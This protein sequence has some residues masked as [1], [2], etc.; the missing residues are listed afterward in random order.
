MKGR[1]INLINPP[2]TK[3]TLGGICAAQ[4]GGCVKHPICQTCKLVAKSKS[5]QG[6]KFCWLR[7][8]WSWGSQIFLAF[9]QKK[10]AKRV[11]KSHSVP[12]QSHSRSGG[13]FS[14]HLAGAFPRCKGP[15]R[16]SNSILERSCKICIFEVCR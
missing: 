3:T 4:T 5:E 11:P 15:S 14:K 1:V 2:K 9:P 8:I 6:I 12:C 16:S 10:H 7:H 13:P